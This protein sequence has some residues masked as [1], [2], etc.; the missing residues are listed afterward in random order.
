MMQVRRQFSHAQNSTGW[1]PFSHDAQY[2]DYCISIRLPLLINSVTDF[3]DELDKAVID[4]EFNA[5]SPA[6]SK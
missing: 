6:S 1:L 4:I 3:V 2:V 5:V